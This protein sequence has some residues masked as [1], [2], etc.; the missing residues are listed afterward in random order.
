MSLHDIAAAG[1]GW[2]AYTGRKPFFNYCAHD[3]NET[4]A[5]ADRIARLFDPR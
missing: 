1:G 5:D 2:G 3:R 4:D